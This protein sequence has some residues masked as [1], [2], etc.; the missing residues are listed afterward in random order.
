MNAMSS[1][2]SSDTPKGVR[3][4]ATAENV[5]FQYVINP[6]HR[7]TSKQ[8]CSPLNLYQ[9]MA[10]FCMFTHMREV[11]IDIRQSNPALGLRINFDTLVKPR[12]IQSVRLDISSLSRARVTRLY[13][14]QPYL[15]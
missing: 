13:F 15:V 12:S 3:E 6:N 1:Q 14:F 7:A 5:C 4:H 9:N 11:G 8:S 2:L 10:L